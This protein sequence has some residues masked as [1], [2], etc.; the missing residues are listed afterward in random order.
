MSITLRAAIPTNVIGYRV[1]CFHCQHL[2]AAL[3]S[4]EYEQ[5]WT[6]LDDRECPTHGDGWGTVEAV[7]DGDPG[8]M[9][10]LSNGNAVDLFRSLGLEIDW[11]GGAI[12]PVELGERLTFLAARDDEGAPSI[13]Y[14]GNGGAQMIH[15][16]RPAGY[17]AGKADAL[18]AV[19]D[20]AVA[21]GVEV[22]WS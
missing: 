17:W 1:E 21:A 11:D 13:E 7:E 10:N 2:F 18:Q 8:P 15:G 22:V 6:G 20:A 19:V 12:D 14:V 16:G 5:A 4:G 9:V 3:G